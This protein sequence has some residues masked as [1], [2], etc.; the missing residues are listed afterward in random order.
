MRILVLNPDPDYGLPVEAELISVLRD[1]HLATVRDLAELSGTMSCGHFDVVLVNLSSRR[2]Q[3][4]ISAVRRHAPAIPILALLSEEERSTSPAGVTTYLPRTPDWKDEL[5]RWLDQPGVRLTESLTREYRR[6]Q[7]TTRLWATLS[8][9]GRI[10]SSTLEPDRVLELILEQAVEVLQ[11]VGGSLILVDQGSNELVFELALG[12]TAEDIVGRRMAW[13]TGLVGEAAATGQPLLVNNTADDPRWFSGIDEAT[14]FTTQ[15]ILC[16][17]MIA[18]QEVIGVLEIVNK[19]DGSLFDEDEAELLLALASQAAIAITNARLY[20]ST[21]RQAEEV[22]ALL[23][24]SQAI[25]STPD[26]E[27]RLE[28]ISQKAV[29]LVDAD[30]FIIFSLDQD[31]R[32]LVPIM[33]IGDSAEEVMRVV[34]PVGEGISGRV[35]ATGEGRVVNQAH[36]SPEAFLIPDTPREPEGILSVPLTVKGAVIGVMTLSRLGERAFSVHDLDLI[37][38]L[39]NHAAVAI[40]NARLYDDT[41]QRNRELTALYSVALAAGKTLE[42]K[43]LLEET[44]DQVLKVL[45]YEGGAILMADRDNAQLGLTHYQGVP[46]WLLQLIENQLGDTGV[47][48]QAA[49]GGEVVDRVLPVPEARPGVRLTCVPLLAHRRVLGVLAIPFIGAE[50]VEMQEIRLLETLGRQIGVAVENAVLYAEL[51]ERAET[52][53]RAYDELAKIDQLKDELVQNISHELRTPITFIKGYVSLMLEGDMGEINPRQRSSLDIVSNKTEQLIHLVNGILTLQTLTA[54]ML[55]VESIAPILLVSRAVAGAIPAAQQAGIDIVSDFPTEMP[56]I[57]VDPAQ[58]T[59]VL[60][61][62]L[63]NAIK[64]SPHGGKIMVRLGTEPEMVRVEVS[65]TGI[66]IPADKIDRIFDRFFQVDGSSTR[67]FGGAGLGLSICK[68]II[69]AHGGEL[70]VESEVGKGST[71]AFTVPRAQSR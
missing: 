54:E 49:S 39:G 14:D 40:E 9:V 60:D 29:E 41:R 53:Q 50:P 11:A 70:T 10:L 23:E 8:Q 51:Q 6:L 59:Q 62:L 66:G 38:S 55:N 2:R 52:L 26:L 63:N 20:V 30:G 32:S 45:E 27:Q 42:M 17:P 24:T 56:D 3:S 47:V 19:L 46:Q 37:S 12:P 43:P 34:L 65:D 31:N 4:W 58:I 16:A 35:A 13:G 64:F 44:L 15:S 48:R 25:S 68:Q 33:A 21:R 57:E 22:A 5:I 69:D 67:R 71:F 61:N 1:H 18:R 28:T 7:K 36:L